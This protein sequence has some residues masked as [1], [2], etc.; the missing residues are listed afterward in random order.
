MLTA[1]LP[2]TTP[3]SSLPEITIAIAI[4]ATDEIVVATASVTPENVCES[5]TTIGSAPIHTTV[6]RVVTV[7]K[8]FTFLIP[9]GISPAPASSLGHRI[10]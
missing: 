4:P 7:N 5:R 2:V 8:L 1:C 9:V 3:V 6:T 10:G